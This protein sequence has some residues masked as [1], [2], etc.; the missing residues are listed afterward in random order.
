M[1]TI[2]KNY[3]ELRRR[4]NIIRFH[5]ELDK[6]SKLSIPYIKFSNDIGTCF[7]QPEE[8]RY[9]LTICDSI[10]WNHEERCYTI[11]R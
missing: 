4:P 5:Q 1:S 8:R 11:K 9:I 3:D 2:I 6:W 7:L 10:T